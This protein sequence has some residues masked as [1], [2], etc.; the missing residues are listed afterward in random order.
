MRKQRPLLFSPDANKFVSSA[1]SMKFR[2]LETLP[3]LSMYKI[4]SKGPSIEPCGTTHSMLRKSE[5]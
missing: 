4:T 5:F 3:I 1:N 2:K